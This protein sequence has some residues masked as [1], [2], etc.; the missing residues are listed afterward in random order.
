MPLEEIRY[1][2]RRLD[3]QNTH[4]QIIR[5]PMIVGEAVKEHGL[6]SLPSLQH[7][8]D[9]KVG[10][11]LGNLHV[12]GIDKTDIISMSYTC[13]YPDDCK[14][15]LQ[16]VADTYISFLEDSHVRDHAE[17]KDLIQKATNELTREIDTHSK[18]LSEYRELHHLTLKGDQPYNPHQIQLE[19]LDRQRL[20]LEVEKQKLE[21]QMDSIKELE[22]RGNSRGVLLHMLESFNDT[23]EQDPLVPPRPDA[24]STSPDLLKDY[25]DLEVKQT[26]LG[27]AHPEVKRLKAI[28]AAKEKFYN[29]ESTDADGKGEGPSGRDFVGQYLK[30]MQQHVNSLDAM[31][32][33]LEENYVKKQDLSYQM[34]KH[35][36]VDNQ[37]R[38]KIAKSQELI[39]ILGKRLSELE[40]TGNEGGMRA[41][42]IAPPQYGG[43]VAIN[44]NQIMTLSGGLGLIVGLM[45]GYLLEISDTSFRSPEDIAG[46]LGVP[47]LGHIP[48][49][50][51]SNVVMDIESG[52]DTSLCSYYEPKSR[53]SEAYRAIRTALYFST[54]GEGHKLVQV[55]SPDPGDGKSTLAANLAVSIAYSGKKV[56]L[57]DA[58][59]RRPRVH[60]IFGL[61]DE[62]GITSVINGTHELPDAT[63]STDIENLS[64][65]VCG[66]RPSN[67][68]ELLT[69]PRF[70]E[71]LDY[72]REKYDFVI[73]DTPPML[74]V[75]DPSAVSARVDGVFVAMRLKS[76]SRIK[77]TQAVK[78]LSSLDANILGVVV[79][80]IGS[81]QD[82]AYGTS[83]NYSSKYRY[84]TYGYGEDE[85]DGYWF[86]YDDELEM[87]DDGYEHAYHE[88]HR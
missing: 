34:D 4:I 78:M 85:D 77:A 82:H 84:G 7:A 51:M 53:T 57:I 33:K 88:T 6:A 58:D 23:R 73:V 40:L 25:I 31:I 43:Q 66:P 10:A 72:L 41:E 83:Y 55:T 13:R 52:I 12:D 35:I 56:L 60:K 27:E 59:F 2:D 74:A 54:R 49:M 64:I 71:L 86:Y 39:D 63:A 70:K 69:S 32:A 42:L 68:S 47:V 48:V 26:N 30:S 62:V 11:I 80:G 20:N 38:I 14:R 22:A 18:K 1:Q 28:I 75:T 79:N 9:N 81:R 37:L 65:L 67:P 36:A 24:L 44:F 50:D 3:L 61:S 15:I 17:F 8:G 5:S 19:E 87:D 45:L 16:A 76:K 21:G 29:I 46:Q